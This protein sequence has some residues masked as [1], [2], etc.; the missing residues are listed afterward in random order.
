MADDDEFDQE[1]REKKRRVQKKQDAAPEAASSD[2]EPAATALV[3]WTA[4]QVGAHPAWGLPVNT[5][6]SFKPSPAV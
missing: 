2:E 5:V 6:H 4:A 3:D 1:P